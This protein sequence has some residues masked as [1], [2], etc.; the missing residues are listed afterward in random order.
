MATWHNLAER[1]LT[2]HP[3]G[4]KGT[5]ILKEK[6]EQVVVVILEI[7]QQHQEP[8]SFEKL[9][10]L[11]SK[12]LEAASFDGKPL[13]YLVTVKLDLEARGVI[14][15]IAKSSPQQLRLK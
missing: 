5:N 10:E 14:E 4:K 15:R 8:I 2:L 3:Q 1:F 7:M 6:Y 12:Q 9:S 11:G 13:W